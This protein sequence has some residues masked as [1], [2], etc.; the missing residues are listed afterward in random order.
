M[1]LA[2]LGPFLRQNETK[3][4]TRIAPVELGMPAVA[5]P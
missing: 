1:W 2:S 5:A 4:L 3:R